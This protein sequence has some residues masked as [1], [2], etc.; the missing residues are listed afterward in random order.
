MI[1]KFLFP[2]NTHNTPISIILLILRIAFAGMLLTHGWFKLTHFEATVNSFSAMG[3]G[4]SIA[5]GLAVFAE[6]FC[7]LGIIVGLL[8]RLALIP[9]I[10]TMSVAFF[11]VKGGRLIGAD[12]GE[13]AFL[14]LIVFVVLLLAGSGKYALDNFFTKKK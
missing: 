4:G 11:A 9:V 8:Y 2:K 14:Y 7:A 6:F 5:A 1:Q 10:I 12:N 13:L 3:M